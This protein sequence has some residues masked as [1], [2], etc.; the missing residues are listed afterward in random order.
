MAEKCY[1][2]LAM[3]VGSYRD[4]AGEMLADQSSLSRPP[5]KQC[6]GLRRELINLLGKSDAVSALP[7]EKRQVIA[8]LRKCRERL[9]HHSSRSRL[10]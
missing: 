9:A 7:P 5:E 3:P 8:L 10:R 1:W 6:Q 4:C 2:R